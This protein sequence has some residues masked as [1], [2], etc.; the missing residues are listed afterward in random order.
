M[1][2]RRRRADVGVYEDPPVLPLAPVERVVEDGV[3]VSTAAARLVVKNRIIVEAV[4]Y[5]RD[6][7]VAPLL[8]LARTELRRLAEQNDETADRL[9]KAAALANP[10][11]APLTESPR[12]ARSRE[13]HRRR[14]GIHRLLA[15]ALRAE[16]NKDDALEA[17][18]AQARDS[19]AEE[20]SAA[21]AAR[22]LAERPDA[23]PN[24]R[25]ERA[26]RIAEFIELDLRDKN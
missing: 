19:A 18:V 5:N 17:L 8:N 1:R 22:L 7:D 3:L 20:I 16:A 10:A 14:P 23:D 12:K 26:G 2:F 6:F 21:V 4:R 15:A 9:E 25:A 24:Y 13:D 11:P